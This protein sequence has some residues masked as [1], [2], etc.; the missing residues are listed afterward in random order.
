MHC[1]SHQTRLSY[2]IKKIK[3]PMEWCEC[4]RVSSMMIST[5]GLGRNIVPLLTP[6]KLKRFLGILHLFQLP[7]VNKIPIVLSPQIIDFKI[8]ILQR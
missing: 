3:H 2:S 1:K 8:L 4:D 6:T 5:G 7:F